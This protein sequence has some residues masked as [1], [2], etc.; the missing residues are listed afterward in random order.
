MTTLASGLTRY[1]APSQLERLGKAAVGIIGAGGLGSNVAVLLVRSGIRHLTIIDHDCVDV[2]NLNRQ[3]FIP[4]D[5]GSPKV[6]ALTRHLL[7][8]EPALHVTARQSLVT[9]HNAITL[10]ADCP[11]IV[12]AVDNAD[13]KMMLYEMFTPLKELYVT[14]SGLAGFGKDGEHPM[15]SRRLRPNVVAVGDFTTGVDKGHPP[16]APRVVQAAAMQADA[17]LTHILS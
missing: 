17:V 10:C 16:L 11:I 1:F 3:Y 12:E 5:V 2:S 9:R 6:A 4:E 13:T 15:R 14:A 7:R 8:L